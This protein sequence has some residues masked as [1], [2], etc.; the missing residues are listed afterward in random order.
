M[1]KEKKQ[2]LLGGAV[3]CIII[4]F[5]FK[6]CGGGPNLEVSLETGATNLQEEFGIGGM[7]DWGQ[8]G[9]IDYKK[10]VVKVVSLEDDGVDIYKVEINKGNCGGG[11]DSYQLDKESAEKAKKQFNDSLPKIGDIFFVPDE[12]Y[13]ITNKEHFEKAEIELR[14]RSQISY[15]DDPIGSGLNNSSSYFNA[16]DID[17][18]FGIDEKQT[19]DIHSI[20]H[21]KEDE[22]VNYVVA[23]KDKDEESTQKALKAF[24]DDNLSEIIANDIMQLLATKN[25]KREKWKD[26]LIKADNTRKY[27]KELQNKGINVTPEQ[28]MAV[29]M[30]LYYLSGYTRYRRYGG[31][32]NIRNYLG[33]PNS[34][35]D[36]EMK[37]LKQLTLDSAT[38][39]SLALLGPDTNSKLSEKA[40]GYGGRYKPERSEKFIQAYEKQKEK[41]V[42]FKEVSNRQYMGQFLDEIFNMKLIKTNIPPM[43][44]TYEVIS[45]PEPPAY[46]DKHKI[47]LDYGKSRGFRI[48]DQRCK[49]KEVKIETDKGEATYSF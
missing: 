9:Q 22:I 2:Q 28:Y 10:Q 30:F 11:Y 29:E 4:V 49:V 6:A 36:E 17:Y 8:A 27:V 37:E 26:E 44:K 42:K 21:S 3:L 14:V 19:K 33:N 48:Y 24:F 46:T 31:D 40:D 5:F 34:W 25:E 43:P 15:S 47:H 41:G 35:K 1:T 32:A 13:F 7:I 18:E 38:A 45:L 12:Q 20:I 39:Y 23:L 16:R